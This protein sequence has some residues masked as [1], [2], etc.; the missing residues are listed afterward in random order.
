MWDEMTKE[1]EESSE[2]RFLTQKLALNQQIHS[3]AMSGRVYL[4]TYSALP[5]TRFS[6]KVVT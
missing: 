2:S 5:K 4:C 1:Q 3:N 6:R